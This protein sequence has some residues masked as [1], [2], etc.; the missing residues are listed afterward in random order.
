VRGVGHGQV[1]DAGEQ[2]KF[3]VWQ[4][5]DKPCGLAAGQEEVPGTPGD[6]GRAGEVSDVAQTLDATAPRSI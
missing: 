2:P 4:L 5:S 6:E 3:R 1:P